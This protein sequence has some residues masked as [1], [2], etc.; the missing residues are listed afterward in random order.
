MEY[1]KFNESMSKLI[2]EALDKNN[3]IIGFKESLKNMI[4]DKVEKVFIVR[5]A[6]ADNLALFDH[7]VKTG[8]NR[9]NFIDIT[10]DKLGIVCKK[11]FNVSCVAILREE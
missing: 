11:P 5:N 1:V 10:N 4:D 3:L 7:Y 2:R 6:K 8:E 9:I